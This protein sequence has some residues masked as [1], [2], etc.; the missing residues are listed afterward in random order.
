V[1][2]GQAGDI[3]VI[4]DAFGIS[5]VSLRVNEFDNRGKIKNQGER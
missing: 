3:Q 1:R 4:C 2:A 5:D